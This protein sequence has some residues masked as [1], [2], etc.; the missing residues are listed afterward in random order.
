V[1]SVLR[2]F[3]SGQPTDQSMNGFIDDDF[4]FG[5]SDDYFAIGSNTNSA[6]IDNIDVN[7]AVANE[8]GSYGIIQQPL[9]NSK[10]LGTS[11]DVALIYNG[12]N[13]ILQPLIDSNVFDIGADVTQTYYSTNGILQQPVV[14]S[15]G[16]DMAQTNHTPT[17]KDLLFGRGSIINNHEGNKWY[18]ARKEVL[19][20]EYKNPVTSKTRKHALRDQIVTEVYDQDG[21]FLKKQKSNWVVADDKA[22]CAKVSQRLREIV[23]KESK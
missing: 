19:G 23:L 21:R 18:R 2:I 6:G 1:V 14:D 3:S 15:N 8:Y 17:K 22:I 7:L 4:S 5:F 10:V 20:Q 9:V 16:G 11:G 13:C 12:N